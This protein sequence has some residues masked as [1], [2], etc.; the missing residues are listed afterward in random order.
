MAEQDRCF[1]NLASYQLALKIYSAACRL[2]SKLPSEERYNLADQLRR[3]ALSAF[4]AANQA[5]YLNDEQLQWVRNVELEAEK[6]LN[7]YI[8]FV[9]KQQL[10]ADEYGHR[11]IHEDHVVYQAL[12]LPVLTGEDEDLP[13]R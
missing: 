1:E 7:G 8:S 11:Y 9:R 4:I 12:P 10:G 6:S 3:A 13:D 5:G 2:A